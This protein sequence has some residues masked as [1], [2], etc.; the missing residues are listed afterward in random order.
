MFTLSRPPLLLVLLLA[1]AS[2]ASGPENQQSDSD[3]GVV[4]DAASGHDA[5]L[6]DASVGQDGGSARELC[7]SRTNRQVLAFRATQE[8]SD[9]PIRSF[10][11]VTRLAGPSGIAVDSTH[12]EI[13]V[14]NSDTR[15]VL[16]FSRTAAGNIAPLRS[17][18]GVPGI[19][20]WVAVDPIDAEIYAAQTRGSAIYVFPNETN[21]S[22]SP[23]RTITPRMSMKFFAFA[24]DATHQELL[25]IEGRNESGPFSVVTYDRSS[26]VTRTLTLPSGL[27]PP[28]AIAVD[29][30]HD[31]FV[32]YFSGSGGARVQAY[33]RA[34]TGTGAPLRTMSGQDLNF[35]TPLAMAIDPARDEIY[36][37]QGPGAEHALIVFPRDGNGVV[38]LLRKVQPD[39]AETSVAQAALGLAL[40]LA[41]DELLI[42]SPS[43]DAVWTVPRSAT[44]PVPT[45]RGIAAFFGGT[46][47][48]D[49]ASD[50]EHDTIL[51]GNLEAGTISTFPRSSEGAGVALR[52][53]K[54]APEDFAPLDVAF[55][56]EAGE[57]FVINRAPKWPT[58]EVF[59][60]LAEGDAH[61]LRQLNLGL[62]YASSL[63]VDGTHDELFVA[64][65]SSSTAAPYPN[66]IA[67]YSLDADGAIDPTR[68]LRGPAHAIRSLA[69]DS[70]HDELFVLSDSTLS[71]YDRT[72]ANETAPIRTLGPLPP[73][74]SDL[75]IDL[76]GDVIYL[77][78]PSGRAIL[79]YARDASG[80]AL[81]LRSIVDQTS[82]AFEGFLRI[83]ICR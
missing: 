81:P 60:R 80:A 62:W 55:E 58:V 20:D 18:E 82:R 71:V 70:T 33:D 12:D 39:P 74:N 22:A 40:D 77:L 29:E 53:L 36:A 75:A 14:A 8:R 76:P 69:I 15:S 57:I 51:L 21:G 45:V 17:I 24:F 43:S 26:S 35:Y 11:D 42:T 79:T 2:C 5:G 73:G 44:G 72:A 63:A 19:V 37:V 49:L 38:G 66:A 6:E 1:V 52:E 4:I 46:A 67:T 61:P 13:F 59:P 27:P 78:N 65:A 54:R 64:L 83:S 25:A 32:V 23:T 10:G 34:A 28:A 9:P 48:P 3:A 50:L 7:V 47:G 30:V 31:E 68:I 41:N 56:P 16:V